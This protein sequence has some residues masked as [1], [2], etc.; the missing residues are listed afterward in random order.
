MAALSDLPHAY[1]ILGPLAWSGVRQVPV[2]TLASPGS[3]RA[4]ATGLPPDLWILGMQE[5]GQRT[6]RP[7]GCSPLGLQTVLLRG[8]PPSVGGHDRDPG[9]WILD[10]DAAQ[11]GAVA[12]SGPLK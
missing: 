10:V 9:F 8:E 1:R 11:D 7:P 12:V 6:T 4:R 2:R 5:A 3:D